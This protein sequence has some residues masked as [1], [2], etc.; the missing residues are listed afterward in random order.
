MALLG[1]RAS[2]HWLNYFFDIFICEFHASLP[3]GRLTQYPSY[4]PGAMIPN[5]FV[6][7]A[8][9]QHKISLC[10]GCM[11]NPGGTAAIL[12]IED[13]MKQLYTGVTCQDFENLMGWELEVLQISF[14]LASNF[15]DAWQVIHVVTLMS[16]EWTWE[17]MWDQWTETSGMMIGQ[18]I[19]LVDGMHYVDKMEWIGIIV[20]VFK[21]NISSHGYVHIASYYCFLLCLRRSS[22]TRHVSNIAML[23]SPSIDLPKYEES[24][25]EPKDW[26]GVDLGTEMSQKEW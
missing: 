21:W 3:V 7:H 1:R 23:E 14:G 24:T 5:M 16:N 22:S 15:Y 10:M 20:C 25:I 12:N 13:D 2:R 9:S 6:E 18:A 19:W 11:C 17:V 26:C 4:L 8:A